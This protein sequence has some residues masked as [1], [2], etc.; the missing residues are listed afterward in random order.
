MPRGSLAWGGRDSLKADADIMEQDGQHHLALRLASSPAVTA[1]EPGRFVATLPI[2][3]VGFA[4]WRTQ[5][6][7]LSCTGR[8]RLLLQAISPVTENQR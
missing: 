7:R 2:T 8:Q 5:T 3:A 6:A 4:L 1:A